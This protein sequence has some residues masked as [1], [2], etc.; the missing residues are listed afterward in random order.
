MIDEAIHKEFWRVTLCTHISDEAKHCWIAEIEM[1]HRT[2]NGRF[3][4]F[5]EAKK[6]LERCTK[7]NNKTCTTSSSD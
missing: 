3:N 7:S 4:T 1:P 2:L 5:D 6:W